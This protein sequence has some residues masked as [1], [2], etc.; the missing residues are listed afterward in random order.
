MKRQA[1]TS[2]GLQRR[3]RD[4]HLERVHDPRYQQN[5]TYPLASL[6]TALVVGVVSWLVRSVTSNCVPVRSHKRTAIGS[7]STSVSPTTPSA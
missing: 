2:K 3:L 5:V 1:A 7:A 4:L 6:L